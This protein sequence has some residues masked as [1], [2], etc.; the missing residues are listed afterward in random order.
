MNRTLGPNDTLLKTLLVLDF[1]KHS[2]AQIPPPP[3]PAPFI[4][5]TTPR[6]RTATGRDKILIMV[7]V[8]RAF[9]MTTDRK[10]YKKKKIKPLDGNLH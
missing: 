2:G 10:N 4:L 6:V 9:Q 5:I 3:R 1:L 7:L 8:T